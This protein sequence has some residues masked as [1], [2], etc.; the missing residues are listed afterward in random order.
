MPFLGVLL[1]IFLAYWVTRYIFAK[2][3]HMSSSRHVRVLERA[4]LGQDKFLALVS[5]NKRVYL[6]GVTC[7]NITT[8]CEFDGNTILSKEESIQKTEFANIFT[9]SLQESSFFQKFVKK[10]ENVKNE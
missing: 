2:Y 4:V 3:I 8:V 6:L 1:V 9:G 10:E 5:V 7:Q